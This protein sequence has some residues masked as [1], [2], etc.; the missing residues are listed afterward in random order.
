MMIKTTAKLA[1][2]AAL[3]LGSVG[4]QQTCGSTN[5]CNTCLE[6]PSCVFAVGTCNSE[7]LEPENGATCY[8]IQNDAFADVASG[9]DLCA[10]Y[11]SDNS[12]CTA[13]KSCQ[14]CTNTLKS[15]GNS[16]QWYV[17]V[18]ENGDGAC[19]G[20]GTGPYGP[21][22]LVCE[23][24]A[25]EPP[26]ETDPP[27]TTPETDA[28]TPAATTPAPTPAPTDEADD[29]TVAPTTTMACVEGSDCSTCLA[30]GCAW[31]PLGLCSPTCADLQDADCYSAASFPD[32][33][34]DGICEAAA[35]N[36]ADRELCFAVE[37]C[38]DCTATVKSDGST[39]QWYIDEETGVDWCQAGGC[40]Q[41]GICGLTI[42]PG[43]EPVVT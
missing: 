20:G 35:T 30:A 19:F 43:Q 33:D 40:D 32:L 5:N 38:G 10:L 21:G 17:G 16:C 29:E 39:C 22:A 37:N 8:S 42:C 41:D 36:A 1:A 11:D 23:D 14:D 28:P 26:V 27:T 9:E 18:Y 7:C 2:V 12:R 13:Q 4:A 31:F 24:D 6:N 15:D 3:L 34:A 25:T